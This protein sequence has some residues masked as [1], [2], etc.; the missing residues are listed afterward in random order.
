[1][2]A[3]MNAEGVCRANDLQLLIG[4]EM[5]VTLTNIAQRSHLLWIHAIVCYIVA[6]IVMRVSL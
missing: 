4:D 3:H 5:Q 6:F 1:M 2:I